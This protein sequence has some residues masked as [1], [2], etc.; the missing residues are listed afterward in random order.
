MSQVVIVA[1]PAK[2]DYIWKISSDKV[3]HMTLLHLGD[4]ARKLDV[5]SIADF[6]GHV[7]KT[8]MQRFGMGVDHRGELGDKRADVLFF[9]EFNVKMLKDVRSFLLTNT[10]IYEAFHSTEQFPE[11]T[12]HLT[13]GYPETPAKP[14]KREFPGIS[15][16]NFDKIALWT[17]DFD[18]PEY[19]LLTQDVSVM[20]MSDPVANVLA[21]F[22]VKGMKWGVRRLPSGG[23]TGTPTADAREA[24]SSRKK[25]SSGGTH[26]LTTK[27][28]QTLVN[29]MNLEQQYSRIVAS[30]PTTLD[31]G[32]NQVKQFLGLASTAVQ[33]VNLANSAPA[34]AGFALVKAAISKG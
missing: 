11:F 12:P 28:L 14:D 1:L 31:R 9:D 15:W 34:K 20:A 18:G 33:V 8:S 13:L 21:H 26:A 27:E 16:V 24:D 3:P 23:K 17:G 2:D 19:P 29:R 25:I 22:G 6:L 10:Q 7:T 4:Q 5:P 32:H 30:Q